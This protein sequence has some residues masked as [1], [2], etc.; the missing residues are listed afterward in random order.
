MSLSLLVP[1]DRADLKVIRLGYLFEAFASQSNLD[2]R[3]NG[4]L[5][6]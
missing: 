3:P 6:I 2:K 5:K 4:P 1:T